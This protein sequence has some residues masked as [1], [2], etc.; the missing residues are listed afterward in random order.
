M[1]GLSV[2]VE[3]IAEKL[4]A[5]QAV[6]AFRASRTAMRTAAFGHGLEVTENAVLG[7]GRRLMQTMLVEVIK[8]HPE[9]EKGGPTLRPARAGRGRV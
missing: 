2:S 6:L 8:A 4:I 5:E 7:E 9:V 3:C 1:D